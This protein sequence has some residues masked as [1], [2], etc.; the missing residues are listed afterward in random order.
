MN[1]HYYHSYENG[2]GYTIDY[3][4]RML[5]TFHQGVHNQVPFKAAF[6]HAVDC[7]IHIE[8]GNLPNSQQQIFIAVYKKYLE[9]AP[10]SLISP[11]V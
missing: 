8:D 6:T 1:E 2:T 10:D 7:M 3:R 9:W 11:T 4:S 5:E